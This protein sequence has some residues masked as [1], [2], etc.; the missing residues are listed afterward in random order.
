MALSVAYQTVVTNITTT[1]ALWTSPTAA[2]LPYVRDLVVTNSGA[3]TL[4]VSCGAAAASAVTT[5]SFQI[6]TG[7]SIVLM[8]QLPASSILYGVSSGTAAASIG[9]ASVVSVI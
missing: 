4:F 5:S 6:P 8:G 1:T 9:Y 3:S 2:T 7:Q